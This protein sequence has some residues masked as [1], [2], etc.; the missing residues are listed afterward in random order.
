MKQ[1]RREPRHSV[2]IDLEMAPAP[3]AVAANAPAPSSWTR[4]ASVNL[5]YGGIAI[6]SPASLRLRSRWSIRLRA[7]SAH[8]EIGGVVKHCRPTTD[9]MSFLVGLEFTVL[10]ASARAVVAELIQLATPVA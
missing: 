5:S 8:C 4:A 2:R 9:W 7:A 6:E 1:R 10:D 3:P